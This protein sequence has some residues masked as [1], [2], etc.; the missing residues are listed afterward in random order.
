MK[1]KKAVCYC[2]YSSTNQREESINKQLDKIEEYCK[3]NNLNLVDRYIDEAKTGTNDN[4][5]G[6]QQ[7]MEDAYMS[8][9]DFVVVYRMNRL[10]RSVADSMHYKKQL[11]KLGIRILSVI[12]DFDE[13]TPEGGFFNLITMGISE[14]YVKN[15]AREAFAGLMQ[16]ANKAIHTGGI[17]PLGFNLNEEKKL[18]INKKEAEAVR[19][20]F[21]LVLKDYSYAEIAR[22]LNKLG[23]RTKTGKKFK[24]H[25]TDLLQNRKYIGEYVYNRSA[26][27][28]VDGTRNHHKNKPDKDII[29][30][31]NAIP[32][33]VNK[34]KFDKVQRLLQ[35][36]KHSQYNR[37]PKSKYLLSG[38]IRCANCGSSITG[39]TQYT[40]S[41]KHCRI[42]Y[43]CKTKKLEPCPTK[44]INIEYMD[45]FVIQEINRILS[46]DS[47]KLIK[48][49]INNQLK[50]I[51]IKLNSLNEKYD[52]DIA[53]NNK[54]LMNLTN[55]LDSHS[56]SIDTLLNEQIQDYINTIREIK[57]EQSLIASDLKAINTVYKKDIVSK[58][59]FYKD[60]FKENRK[61]AVRNIVKVIEQGNEIITINILL[62]AF[63]Q[64]DL[65]EELIY[66][67]NI[68]RD[69]L[70]WNNF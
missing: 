12:E 16:N 24:S 33:I 53:D 70:A 28:N 59:K 18:V 68:D 40:G 51:K 69:I 23:Y 48:T 44:P 35:K 67:I 55:Q 15:L 34:E 36:R 14:F 4:R 37:G 56:K 46:K 3:R 17:P 41:S 27:K 1:Q 6:F 11:N 22:I 26:K 21:D 31:P 43:R 65:N 64:Y 7:M 62:N 39:H 57:Y 10:S 5:D 52:K 30:I 9:W 13:T 38:L 8:D 50:Q 42:I 45:R 29:R 49:E 63:I 19:M 58:Q 2:R 66:R 25:L 54:Q 20:I 60:L 61:E 32:F 47:A